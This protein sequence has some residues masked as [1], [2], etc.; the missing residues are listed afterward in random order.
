MEPK[1]G[2]CLCS[3]LRLTPSC[4]AGEARPH[5]RHSCAFFATER[6]TQRLSIICRIGCRSRS[7]ELQVLQRINP[8]SAA[9]WN[10]RSGQHSPRLL[11]S[12]DL[13]EV[14]LI[15]AAVCGFHRV[16]K[17]RAILSSVAYGYGPPSARVC[18]TAL[19][20]I[21]SPGCCR[22]RSADVSRINPLLEKDTGLA[23]RLESHRAM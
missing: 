17:D 2:I 10:D 15:V 23:R 6:N 8:R 16:R 18:F 21:A 5:P 20:M 19:M 1:G 12:G 9:R 11:A 22:G 7:A 3:C 14:R 4:L 13:P